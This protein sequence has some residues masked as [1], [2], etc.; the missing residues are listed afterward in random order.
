MDPASLIVIHE[1]RAHWA[2]HLR[3]RLSGPAVRWS[4]TRSTADLLASARRSACPIVVLDLGNRPVRGLED[5]D[6]LRRTAP[7]SLSLVLDPGSHPDVG[8]IA[9][10]LG[11]TL[12]LPGVVVAPRVVELLGRW[13]PLARRRAEAD[14][15][16]PPLPSD[17]D[18][19]AS[20]LRSPTKDTA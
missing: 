15:W 18:P 1:R 17:F 14:G 13:L 19:I 12:V 11:A 6:S 20:D 10:E 9:R 7:N 5:L 16:M 3:P 4:E 8:P 2:R